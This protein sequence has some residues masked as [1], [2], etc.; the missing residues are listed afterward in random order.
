MK[1]RIMKKLSP[2]TGHTHGMQFGIEILV[3]SSEFNNIC[4]MAGLYEN[5]GRYVCKQSFGSCLS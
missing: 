2:N 1:L 3:I 5:I 4:A